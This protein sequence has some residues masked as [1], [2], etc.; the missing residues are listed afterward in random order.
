M[1][2]LSS[3]FK[4]KEVNPTKDSAAGS[5]ITRKPIPERVQQ[6]IAVKR[7]Q[8]NTALEPKKQ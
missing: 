5:K 3:Y 4:S 2:N 8:M 7:A 1:R 6:A